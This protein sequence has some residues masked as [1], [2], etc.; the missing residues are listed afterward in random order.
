M[1]VDRFW[2]A[3]TKT[4]ASMIPFCQHVQR[5]GLVLKDFHSADCDQF[6]QKPENCP[7]MVELKVT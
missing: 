7:I 3:T 4:A 2:L 1:C 6:K 5:V